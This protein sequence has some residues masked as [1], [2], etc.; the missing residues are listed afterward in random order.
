MFC[1]YLDVEVIFEYW[2]F[3][4]QVTANQSRAVMSIF[5]AASE[6]YPSS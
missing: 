3:V 5:K 6:Q 4:L 1:C 2:M